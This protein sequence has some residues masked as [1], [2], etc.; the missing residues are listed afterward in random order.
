MGVLLARRDS[1]EE[2]KAQVMAM[3]EKVKVEL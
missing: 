1:V 2:A 3:R